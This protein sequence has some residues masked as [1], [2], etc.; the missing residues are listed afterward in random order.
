MPQSSSRKTSKHPNNLLGAEPARPSWVSPSPVGTAF[1]G[2]PFLAFFEIRS[3]LKTSDTCGPSRSTN[4]LPQK[5]TRLPPYSAYN[6]HMRT[7]NHR[8]LSRL[9]SALVVLFLL[10]APLCATRCTLSS[11]ANPKTQEESTTG[12]HHQSSHS[13]GT[14]AL[15]ATIPTT[16]VPADAFLTTLPAQQ[17]PLLSA[18]SNSHA[19]PAILNSLPSP[20][21][22]DLIAFHL[23]NRNCSPGTLASPA[24]NSPLRL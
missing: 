4:F 16:C 1:R 3:S 10:A 8:I 6:K 23:A 15:V 13:R 2:G 24:A 17:F 14:S 18:D 20:G 12:C 21:A 7:G 19:L 11:C 22:S 9:G 5:T